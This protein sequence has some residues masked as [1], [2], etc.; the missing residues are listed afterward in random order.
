M[1]TEL[2]YGDTLRHSLRLVLEIESFQIFATVHKSNVFSSAA[3]IL[4]SNLS[5]NLSAYYLLSNQIFTALT[6]D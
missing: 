6:Y 4:L 5:P 1:G 2:F 3:K